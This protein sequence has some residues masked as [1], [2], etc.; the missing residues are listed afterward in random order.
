[1]LPERI[2]WLR[3]LDYHVISMATTCRLSTQTRNF[4]GESRWTCRDW[5]TNVSPQKGPIPALRILH[6]RNFL[7]KKGRHANPDTLMFLERALTSANSE[8]RKWGVG[9][10]LVGFRVFGA[11]RFSAQTRLVHQ[12]RTI[13]ASDFRVDGVKSQ[14][15]PKKELKGLWAQKSQ[16]E[17]ANR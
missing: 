17:I 6:P 13:A 14:E 15:I 5:A 3:G 16:P 11:P 2:C 7:L 9:S 12:N 8:G 1:M 4:T 10:V